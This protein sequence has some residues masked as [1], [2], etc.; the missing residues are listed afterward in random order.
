MNHCVTSGAST[1]GIA[2]PKLTAVQRMT[3]ALTGRCPDR[4]PVLPKIW[5]DLG[6]A[7]TGTDL[8]QALSDPELAMRVSIDA[9]MAVGAD[10]ARAMLFPRRHV[11]EQDGLICETDK[12][13][14][15]VGPIDYDG[16]LSTRLAHTEDFQLENPLHIAFFNFW[17]PPSPSV[18][19][20]TDARRIAIPDRAFYEAQGY[21]AMLRRVSRHVGDRIALVGNC[22][23]P[24]LAF[25]IYFRGMEQGLIDLIE[26]PLLV[27]AVMEK[28]VAFAVERGKFK[29]DQGIRI[30]RLNDSAANMSVMSPRQW[31]EFIYPHFK[32]VC[33]E[34]HSY[35][36]D[37]KIYCH[38]CGNAL[39][40]IDLLVDAGLDCIGPL[41]PL[42][43]FTVGDARRAVGDEV[44]LMG[45]V[46]TQSFVVA[47]GQEIE[48]E[49]R[50]CIEQGAVGG[51]RYILG[52][53]CVIPR[54]AK[55]DNLEALVRAAEQKRM[56]PE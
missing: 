31:K 16:G 35:C 20:R 28:G 7:L 38:I 11:V 45:G 54:S 46:D 1:D 9:A 55:R 25:Y 29:I 53:G 18:A 39:P 19:D 47:T 23:S 42:G 32:A 36:P 12:Q 27:H 34:L 41:D 5:V 15:V 49:A 56:A 43:G 4:V 37:V 2:M 13:G 50:R 8:R 48:A 26:N 51:R 21:G 44:T 22:V 24:T 40:I 10:G 17:V 52:S 3:A 33:E 30:L 14:R 6:A